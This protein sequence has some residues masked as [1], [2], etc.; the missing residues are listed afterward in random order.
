MGTNAVKNIK[1]QG[2]F[3]QYLNNR[4][5]D[6]LF[7]EAILPQEIINVTNLLKHRLSCGHDG[8][9]IK[10]IKSIINTIAVPL[11]KIFNKSFVS[12]IFPDALKIARIAPVFKSGDKNNVKNYRPI[13]LLPALSKILEKLMLNRLIVFLNKHNVLN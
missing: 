10:L 5:V 3:K 12:G 11:A 2:S 7:L 8:L 13:S 4:I 6:S 1:S 9:S